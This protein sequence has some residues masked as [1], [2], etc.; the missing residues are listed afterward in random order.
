VK[1][2]TLPAGLRLTRDGWVRG[3]PKSAGTHAATLQATDSSRRT[4][5]RRFVLAVRAR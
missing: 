5:S 3:T 2:G 1:A 4:A